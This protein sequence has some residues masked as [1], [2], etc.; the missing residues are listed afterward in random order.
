MMKAAKIHDTG[1]NLLPARAQPAVLLEAIF[2][3][4]GLLSLDL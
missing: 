2:S 1:K 3:S 4:T